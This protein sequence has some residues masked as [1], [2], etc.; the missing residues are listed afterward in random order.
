MLSLI[1]PNFH[2]ILGFRGQRIHNHRQQMKSFGP[3]PGG[4]ARPGSCGTGL[5]SIA[6]QHGGGH[7]QRPGEAETPHEDSVRVTRSLTYWNT[8][9]SASASAAS[10]GSTSARLL[11][12]VCV[13]A[14]AFS[15]GTPAEPTPPAPPAPPSVSRLNSLY[16]FLGEMSI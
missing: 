8:Y 3:A 15:A 11:F 13:P 9:V 1:R 14:P 4:R 12:I 2:N 10:H 7:A 6:G 16:I 5:G